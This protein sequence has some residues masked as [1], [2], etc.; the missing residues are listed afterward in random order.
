MPTPALFLIIATVLPLASFLLLMFIGKRM[1]RPLAGW[2]ATGAIFGSF[3]FSL[4]A[5]AAWVSGGK[6]HR[7]DGHGGTQEVAYGVAWNNGDPTFRPQ[8]INVP[9]RWIPTDF[10]K[11]GIAQYLYVGVYVDS[12]TIV[13]FA[14][15]T[16]VAFLVHVFSTGYMAEDK[17]FPRFFTYLGLFCFSMLG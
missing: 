9:F 10:D 5:W 7:P 11:G 13:M 16:F 17:R 3:I 15:I 4:L 1:G 2:V 14:M 8:A 6:Y 12:L